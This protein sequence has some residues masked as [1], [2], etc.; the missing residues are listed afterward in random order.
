VH[1]FADGRVEAI[2]CEGKVSLFYG[3]KEISVPAGFAVQTLSLQTWHSS[4]QAE[5]TIENK[6]PHGCV[7]FGQMAR[8]PLRHV[9][10]MRIQDDKLI[11]RVA[12]EC[13]REANLTSVEINLLWPT[14][15]S[16]WIYGDVEGVFPQIVPGDMS[17]TP[18]IAPDAGCNAAAAFA[19]QDAAFP[20]ICVRL[21]PLKP[22]VRLQWS[23][24]DYV[25]GAR[26]L[27][28]GGRIPEVELPLHRG[29]HEI[30]VIE[31]EMSKTPG[32]AREQVDKATALRTVRCGDTRMVFRQGA[33]H[34]W[35][36]PLEVSRVPHAYAS[37]H[38]GHLWDDSPNLQWGQTQRSGEK[39][40][41]SG[42]SRRFPY[43]LHVEC[44]PER[45]G[46]GLRL[47]IEAL[48]PFDVQ[49]YQV[50]IVLPAVYNRWETD[51]ESGEFPDFAPDQNDWRHVNALYTPGT[52]A[53]ALSSGAPSVT[54]VVTAS[55]VPFRMTVINTDYHLHARVLQ[56]LRAPDGGVLHYEC[57]RFLCFEGVIV[58]GK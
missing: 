41:V 12:L 43:R 18:I 6:T 48:R 24:T 46:V 5:W 34:L 45:E 37:L 31:V 50:S 9:W 40:Y 19:E 4:L 7:A 38:T 26:A 1:P 25:S 14:R 53:R 27:Q 57:G 30:A 20:C 13:E 54:L 32:R 35:H 33:F 42:E 8:L 36:G 3:K 16:H 44:E 15:L 47:W 51:H 56:A 52:R 28:I 11:W 58:T 21:E 55:D 39:L 23:N 22:F 10:D 49:E 2:L 29:L 17:W